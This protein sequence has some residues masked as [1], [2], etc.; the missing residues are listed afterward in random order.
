MT[1][2]SKRENS[3]VE[4]GKAQLLRAAHALQSRADRGRSLAEIGST[5]IGEFLA[6]DVSP[7]IL[8]GVE[9]WSIAGQPLDGEPVGLAAEIFGHVGA[10]MSRQSV[11]DEDNPA[12][13]E[14]PSQFVEKGNEALGVVAV[15]LDL[16]EQA[17]ALAVEPVA[18]HRRGRHL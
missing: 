4:K 3:L 11:P 9:L 13:A 18:Q 8:D 16:K 14:V 7:Q 12:T 1:I 10:A 15:G 2:L 5:E 6:F 17:A